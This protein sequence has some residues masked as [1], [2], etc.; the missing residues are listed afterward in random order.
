VNFKGLMTLRDLFDVFKFH[1]TCNSFIKYIVPCCL[2]RVN[3]FR[4]LKIIVNTCIR[5]I[6]FNNMII[7]DS[8]KPLNC[9]PYIIIILMRYM[10]L[11]MHLPTCHTN[12][13]EISVEFHFS[14]G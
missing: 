8:L 2:Y 11:E 12:L 9:T 14:F 7:T 13:M 3:V 4:I 6:L 5:L 10:A 1:V